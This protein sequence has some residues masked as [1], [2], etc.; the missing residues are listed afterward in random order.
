MKNAKMCMM[1]RGVTDR[2]WHISPPIKEKFK[3]TISAR[4]II[5]TAF[6]DKNGV[7]LVKFLPQGSTIN[8]GVYCD[9]LKKLS[10]DPEHAM[11][12]A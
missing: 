7:L 10:C 2:L 11:W 1:F 3:Q 5:C 12:N 4:K 8:A 9:T 6:W